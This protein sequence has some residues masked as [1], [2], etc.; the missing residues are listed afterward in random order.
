MRPA[1]LPPAPEFSALW[2]GGLQAGACPGR[3]RGLQEDGEGA[4][5]EHPAP[6]A[7]LLA[8]WSSRGAD[9]ET[10]YCTQGAGHTR[11]ALKRRLFHPVLSLSHSSGCHVAPRGTPGLLS[12]PQPQSDSHAQPRNTGLTA[13][14]LA[15]PVRARRGPQNPRR[16]RAPRPAHLTQ[17]HRERHSPLHRRNYKTQSAARATRPPGS[18]RARGPPLSALP[19]RLTTTGRPGAKAVTANLPEPSNTG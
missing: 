3:P 1:S 8:R 2:G 18:G 15:G 17:R 6:P 9:T 13:G 5:G 11:T 12:R 4:P 10:S 7:S 16:H 19:R 14:P